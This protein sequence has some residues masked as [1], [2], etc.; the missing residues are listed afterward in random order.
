MD[1]MDID[2]I[3]IQMLFPGFLANNCVLGGKLLFVDFMFLLMTGRSIITKKTGKSR[4][5]LY[6]PCH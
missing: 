1:R 4:F 2:L 6:Y 3:H 5:F